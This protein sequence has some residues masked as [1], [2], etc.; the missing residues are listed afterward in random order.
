MLPCEIFLGGLSPQS[1]AQASWG[2][3]RLATS[4]KKTTCSQLIVGGPRHVQSVK[5]WFHCLPHQKPSPTRQ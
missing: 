2:F 4:S 5:D 3:R 1:S